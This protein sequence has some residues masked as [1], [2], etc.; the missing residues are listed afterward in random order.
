[1]LPSEPKITFFCG[2]HVDPTRGDFYAGGPSKLPAEVLNMRHGPRPGTPQIPQMLEN[3]TPAGGSVGCPWPALGETATPASGPRPV[4]VRF[5]KL[6]RAPRVRSASGPRPLPLSPGLPKGDPVGVQGRQYNPSDVCFAQ[7]C[8]EGHAT[9]RTNDTCFCG[10]RVDQSR[11][12]RAFHV[13]GGGAGPG[14]RAESAVT[15]LYRRKPKIT[16]KALPQFY[17]RFTEE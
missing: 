1:M 9:R 12:A 11:G 15:Q 16:A 13:Q 2:H 14:G 17:R 10:H 6:Y 7:P 8:E 5:F 3:C 4:R